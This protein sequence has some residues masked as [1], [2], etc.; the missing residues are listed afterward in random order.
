MQHVGE[1]LVI[2]KPVKGKALCFCSPGQWAAFS[3]AS[4]GESWCRL[5]V[6][7]QSQEFICGAPSSTVV[8]AGVSGPS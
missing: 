8:F 4:C 2:S 5:G 7:E 1:K 3:K 6:K